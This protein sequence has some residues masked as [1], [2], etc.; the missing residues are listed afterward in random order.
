[1]VHNAFFLY[2]T[3][4]HA[5]GCALWEIKGV[6]VLW[7]CEI[8]GA[9]H[10]IWVKKVR[11]SSSP[12][13]NVR[14]HKPLGASRAEESNT[15]IWYDYHA[16]SKAIWYSCIA[17]IYLKIPKISPGASILQRPFLRGLFLEGLIFGGAYL[18]REICVLKLIGLASLIVGSKLIL[19]LL[20]CFTLYLRAIF[21]VQAARRAYINFLGAI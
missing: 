6:P 18:R 17:W 14:H 12:I 4:V 9:Q 15:D 20:P 21:Q 3:T 19:P 1:M 13:A 10:M 11:F 7:T 8:Q 2:H 5:Q 16:C